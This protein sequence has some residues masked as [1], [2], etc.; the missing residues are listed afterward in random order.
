M[1]ATPLDHFRECV[2]L[3]CNKLIMIPSVFVAKI[4]EENGAN[5]FNPEHLRHKRIMAAVKPVVGIFP[6]DI[7]L[8]LALCIAQKYH[9]V[10]FN[11]RQLSD[12]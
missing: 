10:N 7:L 1:L 3:S 5:V 12:S 6:V 9:Q 8:N 2:K 11:E 4:K